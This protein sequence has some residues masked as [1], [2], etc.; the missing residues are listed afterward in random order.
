MDLN[1][2]KYLNKKDPID[3]T[4]L[5]LIKHNILKIGFVEINNENTDNLK[6]YSRHN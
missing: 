1:P 3:N 2:K 4:I 6:N 5:K